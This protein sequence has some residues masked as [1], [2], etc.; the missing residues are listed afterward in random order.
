M[1]IHSNRE[2]LVLHKTSAKKLE[3]ASLLVSDVNELPELVTSTFVDCTCSGP[4]AVIHMHIEHATEL[5]VVVVNLESRGGKLA[6][7]K[8]A[9]KN[10]VSELEP[11]KTRRLSETEDSLDQLDHSA[12]RNARDAFARR[13]DVELGR[14]LLPGE[15]GVIDIE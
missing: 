12:L 8:T 5:A 1:L 6:R 10:V 13:V 14:V 3:C 4:Q 7:D 9:C 15:E 11:P 2:I